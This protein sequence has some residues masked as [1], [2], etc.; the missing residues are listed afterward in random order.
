MCVASVNGLPEIGRPP[1][2]N[3]RGSGQSGQA[4]V[5]PHCGLEHLEHMKVGIFADRRQRQRVE[6]RPDWVPKLQVSSDNAGCRLDLVPLIEQIEETFQQL[7]RI[8]GS[9][10]SERRSPGKAAGGM[11]RNRSR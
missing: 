4:L 7:G 1:Q 8:R 5:L 3:A 6:Q 11:F 9:S 10:S 2:G